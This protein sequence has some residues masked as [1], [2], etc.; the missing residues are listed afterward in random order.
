MMFGWRLDFESSGRSDGAILVVELDLY[1]SVILE[2]QK[3]GILYLLELLH[4]RPAPRFMSA[5]VPVLCRNR[6]ILE[7][8]AGTAECD[9]SQTGEI[10][11]HTGVTL[12][13]R[14][15]ERKACRLDVH[16]VGGHEDRLE[17]NA[18]FSNV[19]LSTSLRALSDVADCCEILLRKPVF[20]TFKNDVFRKDF[21]G[22]VGITTTCFC[23]RI[24]VVVGILEKF[25]DE[26]CIASV[27]ISGQTFIVYLQL[28]DPELNLINV[29]SLT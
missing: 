14:K 9:S 16:F 24:M 10:I 3:M 22:Y 1:P 5:V 12:A 19:T 6:V 18:L 15:G 4:D 28:V 13:V 8:P 17:T 26:A 7:T 20:V 27:E 25:E 21:K 2:K 11:P 29:W 23:S